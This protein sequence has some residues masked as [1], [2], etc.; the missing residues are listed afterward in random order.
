MKEL[1]EE[2]SIGRIASYLKTLMGVTLT[3]YKEKG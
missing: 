3:K 1:F 2:A